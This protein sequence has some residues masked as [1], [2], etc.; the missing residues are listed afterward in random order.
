MKNLIF[1]SLSVLLVFTISAPAFA[2]GKVNGA[3]TEACASIP[4]ASSTGGATRERLEALRNCNTEIMTEMEAMMSSMKAM[5]AQM[6]KTSTLT[7]GQTYGATTEACA[8]IPPASPTGG[9]TRERLEALRL[10]D[11]EV[12]MTQMEAMMAQMKAMKVQID[13]ALNNLQTPENSGR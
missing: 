5:M 11:M 8:S 4:P 3:T 1:S 12:S 13:R 9:A 6:K 2:N 10:C 7:N